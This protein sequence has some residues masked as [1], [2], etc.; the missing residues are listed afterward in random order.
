M[1]DLLEEAAADGAVLV[2]PRF[3]GEAVL[4]PGFMALFREAERR[5]HARYPALRAEAVV[6]LLSWQPPQ[7]LACVFNAC[8]RAAR[9]GLAGID[10]L[11]EP[12]DTEAEWK[13]MYRMAEQAANAGL[14]ITAHAGEF[15]P[16]N[17]A[18]ALRVP[19]LTRL[20]HAVY[21][22]RDP[23][24]LEGLAASGVTVECS[25][26]CNVV[27]GA[28]PS[29]EAHPIRRFVEYGIPVVLASD[30]P[31]QICTTIGR[32]YALAHALGCSSNE[33]LGFTA[34][35]VRAAFA[36]AARRAA[37]LTE[38]RQWEAS[39]RTGGESG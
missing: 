32:E 6:S 21:A 13:T 15:T 4:R 20:G 2:E 37:L 7:R 35:A 5:V 28:V 33:L 22:A 23:R 38:L 36:P 18:A 3:G 19:G 25:L 29:Y 12:Y 26:S 1:E 16:A 17:I 8:L 24:L 11:Y 39:A 31:V 27:L 14:G 30:N 9:E 34:N 10:W